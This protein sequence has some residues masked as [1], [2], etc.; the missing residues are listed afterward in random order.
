MNILIVEDDQWLSQ[1]FKRVLVAADFKVKVANH[2][3]EAIQSIDKTKPDVIILDILITG[4]N[5]LTLLHELQ[6]YGDTGVIP[7][8]ICSSI[9]DE[10]SLEE[11]RH[12]GVRRILDKVKML[13]DD[14]VAAVRSVT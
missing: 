1:H 3:L 7:V 14:L 6:S 11:L 4:N 10:L 2:A 5:A 13:P 9:A 12:Y 8:I